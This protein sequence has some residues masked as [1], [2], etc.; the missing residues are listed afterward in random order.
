MKRA[1]R[2][3]RRAS[4]VERRAE[5]EAR[6]RLLAVA[7]VAL[8]L[9]FVWT[10][11][12]HA[13]SPRAAAPAGLVAARAIPRGAVLTA[14]DIATDGNAPSTLAARRSTLIGW[15]TRRVIAAGEPLRAPA[16]VPPAGGAATD[17]PTLDATTPNAPAHGAAAVRAGQK[18]A[19]VYRDA[20][21]AL[22][23]NGV[24]A[25]DGA[26]G[27]RV[28]VRLDARRRLEGTVVAPGVVRI[29]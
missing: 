11:S 14:D 13:Q 25:Q 5:H 10:G 27:A 24:A 4:S 15:T 26:V 22:R 23:L 7:L 9:L 17:R 6:I 12:A 21:V 1:S 18:V 3:A 20:G 2:V 8:S 16:V 28:G 29:D 19:V